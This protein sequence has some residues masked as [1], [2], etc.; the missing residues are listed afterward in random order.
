MTQ[1]MNV[2][3]PDDGAS[4]GLV[5]PAFPAGFTDRGGGNQSIVR[6][7]FGLAFDPRVAT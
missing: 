2:S 3:I 6:A 5:A 1:A 4:S 7:V